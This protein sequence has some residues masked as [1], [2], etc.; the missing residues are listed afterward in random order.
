MRRTAAALSWASALYLLLRV[1]AFY[2]AI[3]GTRRHHL[4]SAAFLFLLLLLPLIVMRRPPGDRLEAA[5]S[6]SRFRPLLIAVGLAATSLI[7]FRA[8]LS[9]GF[10]ADDYV[11]VDAAR[12]GRLTVWR[13]LF[14][15][16][17]FLVWRPL[18]TLTGLPAPLL[19]AVNVILHGANAALVGLL[20]HRLLRGP[21]SGL[22]AGVLFLWIPSG[23]EAVAW[24]SGLQDVLMTTFALI[25]LALV[26]SEQQPWWMGALAIA[27]LI[28]GL[29]TKETA[30]AAPLLAA[31]I[32]AGASTSEARRRIWLMTAVSLVTVAVFLAIRFTVL[33][34]PASYGPDLTRYGVK[35]LLVRPFATLLV[36]LRDEELRRAP[37][38]PI[39]LVAVVVFGLRVA[40]GR[41]DR[42]AAG[43]KVAVMGAAMVL[44]AVAPVLSYFYIDADLFGSRYL[45]LAQAGWVLALVAALETVSGGRR[46][47][48]LPLLTLLLGGWIVAGTLH[49]ALWTEAARARDGLLA[50]AG[51][52]APNCASWAVY[53]LP[54]SHRG[55]PLFV[56]G[57][58]EAA[59]RELPGRIRV[60]PATLDP[61]EC[62]LTWNGE[63]FVRE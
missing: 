50:A 2:L 24:A 15:P 46:V 26:T 49:I 31:I 33:P 43:F 20:A 19:H 51:A 45:Y 27:S 63:R 59:R 6:A 12:E 48:V 60:A 4:E 53:G 36:P 29:L 17:I 9:V 5:A 14:R 54:A 25:F 56:N 16:V 58:P 7:F 10:L 39:G 44:A 22:A 62:R 35:E 3:G 47:I 13:E 34:L 40:A 42:Y 28:A 8:L 61:G 1:C 38:L 52:T 23:L 37:V 11:I 30:I 55:V 41:W 57:F 18:V 21:W 32:G